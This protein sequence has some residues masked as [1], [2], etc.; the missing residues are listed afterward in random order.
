MVR[1]MVIIGLLTGFWMRGAALGRSGG[2]SM[3][4]VAAPDQVMDGSDPFPH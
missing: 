2:F 1:W 4:S 3:P